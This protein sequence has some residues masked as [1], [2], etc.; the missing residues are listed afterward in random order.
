M[1]NVFARYSG[2]THDA[3]IWSVSQARNYLENKFER[4]ERASY[5][6]G[7]SGYPLEPWFMTP[8]RPAR[9][10]REKL[11]N[12]LHAKKRNIVER[13]IGLFKGRFRYKT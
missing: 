2:A 9:T 4:G 13:S 5:L 11:F 8:Y 3:Y 7:D 6:L 12:K 1:V 10:S